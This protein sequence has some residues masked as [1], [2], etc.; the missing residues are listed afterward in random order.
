MFNTRNSCSLKRIELAINL[1]ANNPKIFINL[2]QQ[3]NE[4]LVV[5]S[6]DWN[7][8]R[9]IYITQWCSSKEFSRIFSKSRVRAGFCAL[10]ESRYINLI[11][12]LGT[13]SM[14]TSTRNLY[15][16]TLVSQ[17]LA[18]QVV[19][20]RSVRRALS[21]ARMMKESSASLRN[22]CSTRP[23]ISTVYAPRLFKHE[24]NILN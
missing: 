5:S 23:L 11:R 22:D 21:A 3:N 1:F 20:L 14:K 24:L 16:R 8:P 9:F 17:S 7:I 19:Y 4:V 15:T 13:L 12:A 2:Q 6:S 10:P 18:S